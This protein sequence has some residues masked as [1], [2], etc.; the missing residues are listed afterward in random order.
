MTRPV[1]SDDPRKRRRPWLPGSLAEHGYTQ[2]T[3][4]ALSYIVIDEVVDG[5]AGLVV[6]EWPAADGLGRLRFDHPERELEIAV[7]IERLRAEVYEHEQA[8]RREPRIGDVF[9][10]V[11]PRELWRH[12]DE[13]PL[14]WDRPLAELLGEHVYDLASEAR[15]VAKLAFYGSAA[16]ILNEE[17]AEQRGLTA[18]ADAP[19]VSPA[20]PARRVPLRRTAT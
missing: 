16:R 4:G 7:P 5:M 9:A 17:E 10:G 11:V 2:D 8:L 14:L 1:E 13:E 19:V 18:P 6:S 15:D 20:T 12:A 3:V